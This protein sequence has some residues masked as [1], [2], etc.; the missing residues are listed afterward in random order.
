[1]FYRAFRAVYGLSKHLVKLLYFKNIKILGKPC[2]Y[3][4]VY[5]SILCL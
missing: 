4:A 5:D 3:G 1:M 2:I